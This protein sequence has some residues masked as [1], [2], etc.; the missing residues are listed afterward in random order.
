MKKKGGAVIKVENITKSYGGFKA[1]DNLS[2]T[3]DGPGVYGLLGPNGAGKTTTM[4]IMTGCLAATEG[5]VTVDGLDIYEDAV[6]IKRRIGYLPEVPPVY[7]D[8]TPAEYLTFV[9]NAKG[10]KR[11]L[12]A[13]Q[14]QHALSA[15]GIL[16][17]KDRLIKQLSKGYRQRVGIAMALIGDP[18]II[19]L[20]EPTAGLDPLQIIEIR[21]LIRELGE[22]HTVLLSSH[23]LPEISAVSDRII[24][25]SKGRLAADD[26]PAGLQLRLKGQVGVS[27]TAKGTVSQIKA[28][29]ADVEGIEHIKARSAA[30]KGYMDVTLRVSGSLGEEIC[31]IISEAMMEHK[32]PVTRLE[33][34]RASLEEIFL[35]LT[36]DDP[37]KVDDGPDSKPGKGES[38]DSDI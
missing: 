18:E 14:V 23:I 12:V 38:D 30:R 17:V 15:T 10:V 4:N 13:S 26:T 16:P 7:P 34:Q 24:I 29:L 22:H 36:Y 25:L 19:I 28:A 5:S 3:L 33:M 9:A 35:D 20:D 21:S 37:T 27:M 2:F 6:A 31:D 1:V 11:N 8:M 32:L